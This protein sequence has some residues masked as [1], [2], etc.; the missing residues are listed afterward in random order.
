MYHV[1][2]VAKFGGVFRADWKKKLCDSFALF[3]R[4]NANLLF[5]ESA[6]LRARSFVGKIIGSSFLLVDLF[7]R[8]F[9]RI[10]FTRYMHGICW[11]LMMILIT[12]LHVRDFNH[13]DDATTLLP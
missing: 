7:L 2:Y 11:R 8:K 12:I 5:L 1:I 9:N 3:R 4:M 6:L 10:Y 13:I